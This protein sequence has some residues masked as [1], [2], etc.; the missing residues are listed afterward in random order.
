[1]R[2][3]VAMILLGG[4][5]VQHAVPVKVSLDCMAPVP[6]PAGLPRVHTR[7]QVNALEIRVE[8]AREAERK[9]GDACYADLVGGTR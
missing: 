3:L 9:R 4:C 2:A 6:I 8:L 7:A 5:A 1:M